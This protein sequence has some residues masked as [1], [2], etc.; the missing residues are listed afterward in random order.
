[1]PAPTRR[2]YEYIVAGLGGLGSS[3]AYR[4]A[5]LAEGEVLG[6]E[7]F[8]LGHR[9]G[10][11]EDRTRIVRLSY[12][13]P[14]YVRLA[15]AACAAWEEVEREAGERLVLRT[16]GLDLFPPGAAIPIEDYASSMDAEGV[17]YER[18][19]GAEVEDRWPVWRLPEGTR[20]LF[21][22]EGGLVAAS[23]ANAVHREL[24]RWH[25]ARLLERSP[26][27]DVRSAGG[28]LDVRAG[29]TSYRCRVLV[30]CADAWTNQ[31]LAP[32]GVRLP[33]TV[34]NEQVSYLEPKDPEAFHPDRFPVWIWM[35]DPSFYG[36]PSYEGSGAKIGQDVGG[37]EVDPDR[38]PLEPDPGY[39]GRL[40][41]FLRERLPEALG[42]VLEARTCPY[43]MPP[44]RDLV[45]DRL[46]EHPNVLVAQGAAHGFKFA[47]LIGRALADLAATG[48]TDL[49]LSPYRIDREALTAEDAPK[50]FLV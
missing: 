33:L 5:R 39:Q 19:D 10:A 49:D 23:R 41:G 17:A 12:H 3:A 11:S 7:R 22:E 15:K 24:A 8:E 4:L 35:D 47:A 18:L 36:L 45:L 48:A 20:A 25:G 43:V 46:P 44:D 38:R 9:R 29:G 34:T 16:G 37:P 27:E 42:P 32:L 13:A 31:V 6:L 1:M 30:V 21:Q 14:H 28:E 2:D 50:R 40:E 26:V